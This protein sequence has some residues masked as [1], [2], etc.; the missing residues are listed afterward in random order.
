MAGS[1]HA[2]R[3]ALVTGSARRV[4]RA[5][6]QALIADGWEVV[7]HARDN[8][9]A[10]M[11]AGE[12]DAHA[13]VGADLSDPEQVLELARAVRGMF[14]DEGLGLL[15][16]SAATFERVE[17]WTAA[18]VDGWAR[19]MDVNA[20]APYLL[21]SH[22]V[23][24]LSKARGS[25]INISDRAGQ[26]HWSAY[27]VH[28]ASKAALDSLTVSGARALARDGIRVNAVSPRTIL[29]LDEWDAAR[30]ERERASGR[31]QDIA[32]F[33]DEVIRLAND[34]TRTGEI[35]QV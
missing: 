18:G 25:V 24:L 26:D 12:L 15:V 22:L 16:N 32:P 27:P 1:N 34:S 9:A 10:A 11:A 31:L 2:A 29:P 13:G 6:A 28:A 17:P 19:A 4:G 21:T 8:D 30:I 5:I 14:C 35:V 33:L 23:P 20:R 3:T 7:L